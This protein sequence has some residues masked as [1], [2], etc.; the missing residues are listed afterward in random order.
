MRLLGRIFVLALGT[1]C[2]FA[3]L[4]FLGR[5]LGIQR[6]IVFRPIAELISIAKAP[7]P[8][9]SPKP[10]IP[11]L[12]DIDIESQKKLPN[13]PEAIKAVYATAW[14]AGSSKKL[15]YLE[16]LMEGTELNAIVIDIK[17]YSGAVLYNTELDLAKK[18]NAVEARIPK[19]NLLL[20]RLHD[21]G[22]YAIARISVFQDTKLAIARPD[23][24][25]TSSSTGETWQDRK[26]LYW[27]DAAAKEAWDYNIAIAKE[28]A[29]RGFDEINFDYIRFASDGNLED[30]KYPFW[31][32]ATAKREVIR[33]FF[34][35]LRSELPDTAISADLFGLTTVDP[36][37]VGIGQHLEYALPYFDYIAPMVYPSHYS[38]GILGYAKPAEH[39]YE[40]IRYSLDTA[41]ARINAY[42]KTVS[43]TA[44]GVAAIEPKRI[45]KIRPWLQ[46]FDL[47]ADYT[48]EMVRKQIQ[49]VYDSASTTE[50]LV[51]GW[52]LWSPSNV[53]TRAALEP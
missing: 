30:I 6:V 12:R 40:I 23:L 53:Y 17:D 45:A 52:M 42:S 34:E 38:A 4:L 1:V 22:I 3:L 5:V 20:K 18:Y 10:E 16:D 36:G 35:Y 25:L 51:Q 19:L 2:A 15:E 29:A 49:A 44:S 13:P 7:D 14:S 21:K 32:G 26:G 41:L 33:R 28:A 8:Q 37:D 43:Q 24:A 31:N 50:N 48:A 47:G 39:P 46:D 9:I 11:V 27:I